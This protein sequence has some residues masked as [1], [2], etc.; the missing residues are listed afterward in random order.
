MSKRNRRGRGRR[1]QNLR[2][3][4]AWC[5]HHKTVHDPAMCCYLETVIDDRPVFRVTMWNSQQH[6]WQE[7]TTDQVHTITGDHPRAAAHLANLRHA[8]LTKAGIDV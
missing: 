8:E 7:L 6:G 1:A 5:D 3:G 2:K 4:S